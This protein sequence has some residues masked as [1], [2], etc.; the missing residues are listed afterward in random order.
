MIHVLI[1]DSA[2][3]RAALAATVKKDGPG[4]VLAQVSAGPRQHDFRIGRG[5]DLCFRR[6][7]ATIELADGDRSEIRNAPEFSHDLRAVDAA[8]VSAQ[9]S[10]R[11]TKK[12]LFAAADAGRAAR[13]EE[14]S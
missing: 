2:V 13:A 10:D 5:L 9:R 1:V 8:G 12:M 3:R 11:A 6:G 4:G 7:S 14:G